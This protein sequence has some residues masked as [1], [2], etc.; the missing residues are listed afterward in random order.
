MR[1]ENRAIATKKQAGGWYRRPE[2]D[3]GKDIGKYEIEVEKE[4]W[5]VGGCHSDKDEF[6]AKRKRYS[7]KK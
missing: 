1:R 7:Q 2:V 5:P 3:D 6:V 4:R